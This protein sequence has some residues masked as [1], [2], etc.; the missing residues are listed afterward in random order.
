MWNSISEKFAIIILIFF[1]KEDTLKNILGGLVSTNCIQNTK[2]VELKNGVISITEFLNTKT[3]NDEN[4]LDIIIC[5]MGYKKTKVYKTRLKMELMQYIRKTTFDDIL[6]LN[7]V[8]TESSELDS[9]TFPEETNCEIYDERNVFKKCS[10]EKMAGSFDNIVAAV[11]EDI[12]NQENY[13]PK[14]GETEITCNP[15]KVTAEEVGNNNEAQSNKVADVKTRY[16]NCDNYNSNLNV[17]NVF[18]EDISK[19]IGMI[20]NLENFELFSQSFNFRI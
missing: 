4:Y 14:R 1:Q 17:N 12:E 6:Q 15:G 3:E 20:V 16:D 7:P 2:I 5:S 8:V 19:I 11:F 9:N 18:E 10:T 13:I